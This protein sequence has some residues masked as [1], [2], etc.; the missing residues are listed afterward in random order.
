MASKRIDLRDLLARIEALEA[1]L[2]PSQRKPVAK[3]RKAA[4]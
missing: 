1:L 2:A 4:K 3:T